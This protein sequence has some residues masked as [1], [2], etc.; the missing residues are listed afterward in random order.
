MA[1]FE[2]ALALTPDDT[3]ALNGC[4]IAL[5]SLNRH[6]AAIMLF[7]RAIATDPDM[8]EARWNEAQSRLAIGDFAGAWPVFEA[9]LDLPEVS[10]PPRTLRAERW[11]GGGETAGRTLL[12]HAE[13][14]YGDTIQFVRYVPALAAQGARVI[15]EVQPALKSLIAPRA[16]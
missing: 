10:G 13:R 16:G 7:R 15:L 6:Q 1:A 4:G 2:R 11:P 12:V 5:Q 3:E 14:G 9:R 8:P